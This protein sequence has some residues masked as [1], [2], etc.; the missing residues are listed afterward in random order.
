[1]GHHYIQNCSYNSELH[2]SS[3]FNQV[4]AAMPSEVL[5]NIKGERADQKQ[6]W[7]G[8]KTLCIKEC[9]EIGV[10]QNNAASHK[11]RQNLH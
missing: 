6:I 1:M 10:D 11:F 7:A 5:S 9:F 2:G 3:S 8:K 4:G